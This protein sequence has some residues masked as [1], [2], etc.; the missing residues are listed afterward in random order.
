MI[1]KSISRYR[2]VSK[3]ASGG[4]G[5]V[6]LAQDTKLERSIALKVLPPDVAADPGVLARFR[7]EAR[8][9]AAVNHPNIVVIHSVE[10][11][12]DTNFITMELIEGRTLSDVMTDQVIDLPFFFDIAVPLAS[13][14]EAAHAQGVTHRDLK[15]ANIMITHTG[16][17][18]VL[19]FGL[20][21]MVRA[22]SED[23]VEE[24]RTETLLVENLILGTPNYMAP[25]QVRSDPADNRS[26]IFAVGAV[27][28]HLITGQRPF[29][30]QTTTEIM[31]AVLRDTPAPAVTVNPDCPPRLSSLI[32]RCLAK[33]PGERFQDVSE[34]RVQLEELRDQVAQEAEVHIHSIAVLPFADMSPQKDQE[35]FCT[36]IAEEIINALAGVDRLK[37]VSRMSSFQYRDLG[38]DTREIGRKLGV[39]T[40]LE[41]SVRK[42]G[43]K[44]RIITQLIDVSD[45]C[46]I[47]S[48]RFDRDLRDIFEVQDEIAQSIVKVLRLTID[49]EREKHLVEVR[50]NDPAAYDFYLRGR[51][52][53]RRW[54]KRNI[55]IA[56]RMFYQA[57]A[58]DPDFASAHA[59]LADTYSYLFMY[60]NSSPE[61]LEQ[62]DRNSA[63]ALELD[64][65]LAEAH[66]SR[67]LALSLS[68]VHE[69]AARSFH[70]AIDLDPHLFEAYYFFARDLVVQGKYEEAIT[71]Y[72]KAHEASP[73]DYQIPI[74][75]AQIYNALDRTEEEKKANR[76]GMELA[77]KA[78]LLNPE[79]ARACYMG[80]GAMIRLGQEKR[81]LQWAKRALALDPDDP[82]ILYNVACNLSGLGQ[83]DEAIDCLERTVKVGAAYKDWMMN[84]T[85][86]DPLRKEERFKALVASLDQPD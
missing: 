2:I 73:D 9:I 36:G 48:Q 75:Q 41:G 27:M 1:S 71:Y 54:G 85:D 80:A 5:S 56:Q 16:K 20:A 40:L 70:T 63:K 53:F 72:D 81:G 64:P 38:G 14:L 43:N 17:V 68:K 3:I 4:M 30:G 65:A 69:A 7:Q 57:S 22:E 50:T 45:G 19:D 76:L 77:E 35:H 23:P 18:K 74:L 15:P 47:W 86:L 42:A 31:A 51:E 44:L 29:N 59:G 32:E 84:D 11:V 82:A 8:A 12:G 34:L 46:H 79:D 61:N 28:Y 60:I 25:E 26:D 13:A 58:I 66:A 62:A 37:V 52:F 24:A 55:Q 67:G 10:E 33:D 83:I 39:H 6:Y 78:I 49:P 21:K